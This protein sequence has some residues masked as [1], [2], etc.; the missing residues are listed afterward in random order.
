MCVHMQRLH[1]EDGG[2]N[3]RLEHAGGCAGCLLQ[4]NGAQFEARL[5]RREQANPRFAFLAPGNPYHAYYRCFALLQRPPAL[6][7]EC[8]LVTSRFSGTVCMVLGFCAGQAV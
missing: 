4:K 8:R 1:V 2:V 7:P 5:R 3:A 6:I